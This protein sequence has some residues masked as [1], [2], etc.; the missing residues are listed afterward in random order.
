M[1]AQIVP[2]FHL[3]AI[4]MS[5]KTSTVGH[6][7]YCGRTPYEPVHSYHYRDG[8]FFSAL[9]TVSYALT[10]VPPGAGGFCVIP[11]S[12]NSSVPSLR[13]FWNVANPAECVVHLPLRKGDAVIF[14]EAL[15]HGALPWI[16]E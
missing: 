5:I 15:T 4:L 8:Q 6:G 2:L 9:T 11:G 3:Y 16:S 10:D 14:T 1:I 12:H 13:Q 7:L